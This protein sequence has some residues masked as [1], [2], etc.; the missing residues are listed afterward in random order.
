MQIIPHRGTKE[1]GGICIELRSQG[2]GLLLDIGLPLV[3]QDKDRTRFERE[4]LK[5]PKEKLIEKGILPRIPGLYEGDENPNACIIDGII[6]TH[7]HQDHIGLAHYVRSDIPLY[8]GMNT[9]AMIKAV[10]V[11]FQD[12]IDPERIHS[13]EPWEEKS[14][15]PFSVIIHPVDHSVPGSYAVEVVS[16][17]KKIFFT[18]D[19]RAHGQI[20]KLFQN[21]LK[22]PPRNVDCMLMEG[23]TLGKESDEFKYSDETKVKNALKKELQNSDRLMLI[24]SSSLNV[25]RIVSAY[26][27]SKDAHR[28]LVMDYYT[29]YVLYLLRKQSEY[30]SEILDNSRFYYTKNHGDKLFKQNDGENFFIFIKKKESRIMAQEIHSSPEKFIVLARAN[31][32]LSEITKGLSP[33]QLLCIWSMWAGYLEEEENRF[34]SFCN[35][36]GISYKTIHTSGHAT[37]DDLKKLLK[38]INPN[39]VIPIHTFAPEEYESFVEKNSLKIIEDG[40]V[41]NV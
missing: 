10:R 41:Y 24:F 11:F 1:I 3:N 34:N 15:G 23:S 27:A 18:G 38:A 12:I 39:I 9:K 40:D 7:A 35:K 16:E 6:L 37:I 33:D 30:Y 2:R 29:A 21:L 36:K 19:L 22:R 14:I 5:E 28:E 8:A 4:K 25:D 17:E 31:R 26:K 13:M 32:S 20:K